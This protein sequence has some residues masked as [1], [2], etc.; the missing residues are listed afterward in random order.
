M[1]QYIPES[2][3]ALAVARHYWDPPIRVKVVAFLEFSHGVDEGLKD[4][5][6]RWTRCPA[7]CSRRV[8]RPAF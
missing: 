7:P 2:E 3:S 8:S 1:P 6:R 4:L 5:V